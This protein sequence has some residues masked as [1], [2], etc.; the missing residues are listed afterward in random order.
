LENI[1]FI[2][3]QEK[4]MDTVLDIYNYYIENSTATFHIKK[5]K[6]ENLKE[7][8][9][10]NHPKYK[11]FIIKYRAEV[12]GYCLLTQHKKREAYDRT[13]DITIYLKHGF[14]G[15]GIGV[16]AAAF[17]ED[18]AKLSGIKVLIASIAGDNKRSIKLFKKM[19][20]FK[21]AHYGKIGEKFGRILDVVDYEKILN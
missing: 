18:T 20:Y 19:K 7:F 2:E 14:T 6:K 15:M 8:I 17:L 4:D 12:C 13:A 5:L 10:I 3:M 1:E 9:F 11:S 21:C 16:K